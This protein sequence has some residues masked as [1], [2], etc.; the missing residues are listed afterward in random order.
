MVFP[1]GPGH[2]PYTKFTVTPPREVIKHVLC[3]DTTGRCFLVFLVKCPFAAVT[4]NGL[5]PDSS[6]VG[7]NSV[8]AL[9]LVELIPDL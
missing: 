3:K 7:A 6:S 5:Q 9:V 1:T 2:L 4:H 8:L